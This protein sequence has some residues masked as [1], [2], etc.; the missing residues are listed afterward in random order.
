MSQHTHTHTQRTYTQF[1]HVPVTIH[2]STVY[3]YMVYVHEHEVVRAWFQIPRFIT[4]PCSERTHLGSST[5]RQVQ[6]H[7]GDK[8]NESDHQFLL[9][10]FQSH[11]FQWHAARWTFSADAPAGDG[12]KQAIVLYNSYCLRFFYLLTLTFPPLNPWPSYHDKCD[13]VVPRLQIILLICA[14][15]Q[16]GTERLSIDTPTSVL[17]ISIIIVLWRDSG[18][19]VEPTA[20]GSSSGWCFTKNCDVPTWNSA[21]IYLRFW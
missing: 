19:F 3:A 10:P 21:K 7:P 2:S 17:S 1:R 13:M 14:A 4:H 16:F 12:K 18:N 6:G 20:S 5:R 15:C 8:E 11:L 9:N